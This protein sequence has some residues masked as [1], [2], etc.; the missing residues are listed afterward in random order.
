M[1]VDIFALTRFKMLVHQMATFRGSMMTKLD[2]DM[3][4]SYFEGAY[5]ELVYGL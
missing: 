5:C 3:L 4:N 1:G 2:L